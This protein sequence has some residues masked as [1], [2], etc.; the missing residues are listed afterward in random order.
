MANACLTPYGN[1]VAAIRI[2]VPAGAIVKLQECL[3]AI[4]VGNGEQFGKF[5][6]SGKIH[7]GM[8]RVSPFGRISR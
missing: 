7:R 4:V 5:S 2:S 6:V 8:S 1:H 3:N